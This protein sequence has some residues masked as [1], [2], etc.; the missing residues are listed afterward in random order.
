MSRERI[1]KRCIC[2][3]GDSIMKSPAVLMPFLAKRVFD[4]EPVMILPEWGMRDLKPGMAYSVC[5]SLQCM[6]CRV[7]FLDIRF[8]DAEMASLYANY[9]DEEYIRLR[10]F[11][12]PGYRERNGKLFSV[13]HSYIVEI[14]QFIAP[15][16]PSNPTVL[17]WGGDTGLNTPMMG[18]ARLVHIYDISNKPVVS[19]ALTVD[20]TAVHDTAYDLI[21]CS[22][23]LEH[24]PYPKEILA[25]I[26][27]IMGCGTRFYLEVPQEELMR[28]HRP[29]ENLSVTK[30]HWH[31]HINFFT[32]QSLLELARQSGLRLLDMKSIT[33]THNFNESGCVFSAIFERAKT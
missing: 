31:E 27:S 11:F 30:H 6:N 28:T 20:L 5:N 12:E 18:Q 2:C 29:K 22:Q 1:A 8:S 10:D 32:E 13:R 23:V 16:V 26:V 4:H 21:I 3:G 15:F 19:G 17:D 9:R 24:V 7:L 33:I 14:E 25:E